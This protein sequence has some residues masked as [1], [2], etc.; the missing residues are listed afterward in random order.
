MAM[1]MLSPII[2]ELGKALVC[3]QDFCAS[4]AFSNAPLSHRDA[5]TAALRPL[6]LRLM[7]PGDGVASAH[8]LRGPLLNGLA[9][10]LLEPIFLKGADSAEELVVG[11]SVFLRGVFDGRQLD[12]A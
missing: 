6:R 7:L 4:M 3:L 1:S 2:A 10:R 9:P 5:L 8:R 12:C 11:L